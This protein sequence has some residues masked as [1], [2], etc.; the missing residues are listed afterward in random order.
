MTLLY[1]TYNSALL[2]SDPGLS[3]TIEDYLIV[4]AMLSILICLI[5]F[6]KRKVKNYKSRTPLIVA[7]IIIMLLILIDLGVGIFN[8]PWS[9]D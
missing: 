4:L 3:W 5:V 1:K 2:I 8:F 9:G 7:A 6:I